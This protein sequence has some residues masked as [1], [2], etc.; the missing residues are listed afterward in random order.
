MHVKKDTYE[1]VAAPTDH[2]TMPPKKASLNT[3]L[4]PWR[5]CHA[6]RHCQMLFERRHCVAS[7]L[8]P[9]SVRC[10]ALESEASKTSGTHLFHRNHQRQQSDQVTGLTDST[11]T[12]RQVEHRYLGLQCSIIISA[13]NSYSTRYNKSY[14][15]RAVASLVAREN[16]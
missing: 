10:T 11:V 6:I 2:H 15:G 3:R 1:L 5:R 12:R 4:V 8:F 7:I 13:H 9:G 14:R 16:G